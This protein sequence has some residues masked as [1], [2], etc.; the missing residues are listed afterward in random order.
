[1]KND[2]DA[3]DVGVFIATDHILIEDADTGE[4]ILSK[5]GFHE[6]NLRLEND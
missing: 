3:D 5:S 1:M 2:N 4:I 6:D